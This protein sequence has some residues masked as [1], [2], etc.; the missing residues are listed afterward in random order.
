MTIHKKAEN[1][2]EERK[3]VFI[4]ARKLVLDVV[5]HGADLVSLEKMIEISGYPDME[6]LISFL[7]ISAIYSSPTDAEEN[8]DVF[9]EIYEF[10]L[11][12][13]STD[14]MVNL[15]VFH[16]DVHNM[17]RQKVTVGDMI[18]R[19]TA[20]MKEDPRKRGAALAGFVANTMTNIWMK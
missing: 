17:V 2:F 20:D 4:K 3:H 12:A 8:I 19:M 10:H 15:T 13:F 14:V 1:V 7:Y 6:F 5:R 18:D 16:T 11:D 9:K